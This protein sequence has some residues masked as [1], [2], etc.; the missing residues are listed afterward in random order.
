MVN[1]LEVVLLSHDMAFF[2]LARGISRGTDRQCT[3]EKMTQEAE[4]VAVQAGFV[5][6]FDVFQKGKH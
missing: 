3:R 6:I 1:W 5:F 2:V 4:F